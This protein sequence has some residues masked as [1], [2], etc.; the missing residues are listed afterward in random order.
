MSRGWRSRFGHAT[1]LVMTSVMLAGCA[2]AGAENL[3]SF[4][5]AAARHGQVTPVPALHVL[6]WNICGSF[7]NCEAFHRHDPAYKV[8]ALGELV[9]KYASDVVF[10]QEVCEGHLTQ[11]EK[12][13][14]N[15]WT[16]AFA[17]YVLHKYDK[18]RSGSMRCYTSK[19]GRQGVAILVR[20][21][22]T[23][24]FS[25]RLPSSPIA[26]VTVGSG[27]RPRVLDRPILCVTARGVRLCTTHVINWG[28]V[29]DDDHPRQIQ[30]I[31][32]VVGK[33]PR[34]VFGGDLNAS[35]PAGTAPT[36]ANPVHDLD[37]VYNAYRECDGVNHQGRWTGEAT[38]LTSRTKIDYLFSDLAFTACAADRGH[39]SPGFTSDPPSDHLPLAGQ[40]AA[41]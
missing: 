40:I 34:V 33:T 15:P 5:A 32:A 7:G 22:F 26:S 8:R 12:S 18:N 20:G 14:G 28:A 41:P 27:A 29:G 4:G 6:S 9:R 19:G 17:P 16:F 21:T 24:R 11:L 23:D 39:G 30:K 10:L 35:P 37:A 38:I 2:K 3:R 25:Q 1:A 31:L 13:L 36:G